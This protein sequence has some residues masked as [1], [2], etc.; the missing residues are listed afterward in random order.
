M[1]LILTV[2]VGDTTYIDPLREGLTVVAEVLDFL[3]V[4]DCLF[5]LE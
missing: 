3:G 1:G 5:D 2:D 4:D